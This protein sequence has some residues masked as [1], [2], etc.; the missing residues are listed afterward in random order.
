MTLL[1]MGHRPVAHESRK[2]ETDDPVVQEW[3]AYVEAASKPRN[4]LFKQSLKTL[5]QLQRDHYLTDDEAAELLR[6]IAALSVQ[7]YV[8]DAICHYLDPEVVHGTQRR[9]YSSFWST[10]KHLHG[11]PAR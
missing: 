9:P 8:A 6:R 3:L 4:E 1:T 11:L 5:D 2:P 7:A 10:V